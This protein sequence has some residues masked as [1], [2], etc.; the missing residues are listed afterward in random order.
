[1]DKENPNK[2]FKE[3]DSNRKIVIGDEM[4]NINFTTT[5]KELEIAVD[6]LIERI[7]KMKEK[8]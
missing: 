2:T 7:N 3:L 1:M 4:F 6:E 5:D 8:W